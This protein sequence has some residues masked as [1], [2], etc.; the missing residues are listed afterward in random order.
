MAR[1]DPSSANPS[2]QPTASTATARTDA[3]G[4]VAINAA[5]S[6]SLSRTT[7]AAISPSSEIPAVSSYGGRENIARIM[8]AI[9]PSSA[10]AKTRNMSQGAAGR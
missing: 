10:E 1:L 9:M 6:L 3:D 8:R 4:L 2:A 5:I 7:L